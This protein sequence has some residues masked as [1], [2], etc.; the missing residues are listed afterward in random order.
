L[1]VFIISAGRENRYQEIQIIGSEIKKQFLLKLGHCIKRPSLI[2]Q[3]IMKA[4][5]LL[6]KIKV[7]INYGI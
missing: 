5:H 3:V 4:Q 2:S 1:L 6:W 7:E